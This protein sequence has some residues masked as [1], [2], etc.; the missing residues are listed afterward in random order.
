[1]PIL[2]RAAVAT[3]VTAVTGLS[4]GSAALAAVPAS[5]HPALAAVPASVAAPTLSDARIVAHLDLATGRMPENITLLPDGSAVVTFALSRQ[6]ARIDSDGSVHLLATVPAPAAG[7]AT[8]VLGS[9]FLGGIVRAADG[10]LYVNYA[11][12]TADLTGVWALHPGEAPR[13]IAALPANGLPNGLALDAA[14]GYLYA[15]DSVLGTVWRIPLAAATPPHGP[16]GT[17]SPRRATS[18]PTASRSTTE[19]SG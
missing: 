10:T 14:H 13:R 7:A 1:M 11:T 3:A 6:I 4:A 18:A 2:K 17:R 15:A 19:R 12:G 8:P 9:P 16:R 5:A